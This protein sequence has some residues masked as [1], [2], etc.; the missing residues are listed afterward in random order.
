[1]LPL[2]SDKMPRGPNMILYRESGL[3]A[4]CG[5]LWDRASHL[6]P[7]CLAKMSGMASPE[8]SEGPG[9]RMHLQIQLP[10]KARWAE[11]ASRLCAWSLERG[12]HQAWAAATLPLSTQASNPVLFAGKWAGFCRILPTVGFLFPRLTL[13]I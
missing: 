3:C 2:A 13:G 11:E 6:C 7:E 4:R 1:M 12:W 10:P 9:S 5:C 8:A